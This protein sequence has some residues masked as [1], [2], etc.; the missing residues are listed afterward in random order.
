MASQ[1]GF[2]LHFP[3][4]EGPLPFLLSSASRLS[5]SGAWQGMRGVQATLLLPERESECSYF[6]LGGG[7]PTLPGHVCALD[8][9]RDCDN[10]TCLVSCDLIISNPGQVPK[11][12]LIKS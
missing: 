12:Q 4:D 10:S 3:D 6:E 8:P 1:G 7:P 11:S 9:S 2:D 5:L